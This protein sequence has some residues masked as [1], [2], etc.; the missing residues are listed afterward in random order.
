M[1]FGN[2][3]QMFR[4]SNTL[5]NY[6]LEVVWW[7]HVLQGLAKVSEIDN[8]HSYS[9]LSAKLDLLNPTV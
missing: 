2:K 9:L 3:I 5:T 1:Y 6:S 8:D 4:D 7:R